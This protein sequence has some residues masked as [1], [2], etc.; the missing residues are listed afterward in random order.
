MRTLALRQDRHRQSALANGRGRVARCIWSLPR[1]MLTVL[2]RNRIPAACHN[3]RQS[4]PQLAQEPQQGVW[5]PDTS[6]NWQ[7][8]CQAASTSL[9][10]AWCSCNCIRQGRCNRRRSGL[11]PQG[12]RHAPGVGIDCQAGIGRRTGLRERAAEGRRE[13]RLYPDGTWAATFLVYP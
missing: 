7:T 1:V 9:W 12:A 8:R 11:E 10:A 3:S 6:H 13:S 5:Q 2:E 4:M